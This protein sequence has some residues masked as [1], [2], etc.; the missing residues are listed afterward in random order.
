MKYQNG[1]PDGYGKMYKAGG[2]LFIGK[3]DN[4][5]A[6]GQCR[7]IF[8][9]GS[10]YDGEMKNNVAEVSKGHYFSDDL[11]YKGSFRNN[12]FDGHG[13]EKGLKHEFDGKYKDG[14]KVEGI[15]K[16]DTVPN[17]KTFE[18]VYEGKF[19]DQGKFLG[20]GTKLSIKAR[21]KTSKEPM[22]ENSQAEKS[23]EKEPT[24][25]TTK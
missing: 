23:T 24:T 15:L 17:N 2:D 8:K 19:C 22:M 4:G 6:D 14:K 7:Y 9:N 25:T 1:R 3:F 11:E 18:Y 5:K 13:Y 21:S 12:K 20:K 16:W 10:Y